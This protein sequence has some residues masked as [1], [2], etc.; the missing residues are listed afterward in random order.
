MR[1]SGSVTTSVDA[2]G[3]FVARPGMLT[4]DGATSPV[5][6]GSARRAF[7]FIRPYLFGAAAAAYLFGVGWTKSRHRA[8]I[9]D[10]CRRFGYRYDASEP[11]ELPTLPPS[12]VAAAHSLLDIREARAADGN[13]GEEELIILCRIVRQA[14]P[15]AIFEFGTFDGRTTLNL[16]VNSPPAARVQTLDLPR[17]ALGGTAAQI[18]AHEAQFVDKGDSGSRYRGTAAEKKI[19]QLYGDSGSFDFTPWYGEIDMVFV[20]ASHTYEHVMND[21]LHAL[22]MLREGHGTI[23]WHDYSR[24]DGVTAALNDLCRLH[25]S[26]KELKWIEGTTLATLRI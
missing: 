23:V 18:H 8:V 14:S 24:W 13:I 16:A 19:T 2:V 6:P 7:G 10:L 21:S 9:V 4:L 20:D 1:S 5:R 3:G 22:G 12:E 25:P 15:L 26:F 11:C 17:K